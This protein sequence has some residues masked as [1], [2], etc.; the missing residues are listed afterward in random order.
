[1]KCEGF[2]LMNNKELGKNLKRLR[3]DKGLSQ[4]ELADKLNYTRQN[5]S[6]WERGIAFPFDE[7]TIGKLA[8]ILGVSKKELLN[9]KELII[10]STSLSTSTFFQRYLYHQ[11]IE[12]TLNPLFGKTP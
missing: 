4:K 5:L 10:A 1:M 2:A 12:Y 7:E 6:K 8:K 3:E 11:H 9:P